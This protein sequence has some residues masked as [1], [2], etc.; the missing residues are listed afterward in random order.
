[1]YG[2]GIYF[3]EGTSGVLLE[4]NWVH[5]AFSALFMQHYGTVFLPLHRGFSHHTMDS[6]FPHDNHAAL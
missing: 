4:K 5:S 1:M 2:H 6:T 3:D